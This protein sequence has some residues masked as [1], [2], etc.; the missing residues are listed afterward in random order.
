MSL[1]NNMDV[2]IEEFLLSIGIFGPILSCALILIESIIAVLP[3]SVFITIN[4]IYFGN[5]IGFIISYIFTVLGCYLS[6]ILWRKGLSSWFHAKV[7]NRKTL[8]NLMFKFSNISTSALAAL[9][10]MP[11]TPAFLVNIA[12]GLC[13]MSR[14]KFLTALIIGKSAMV[15]FW[16]YIGVNLLHSFK[17]PIILIRIIFIMLVAYIVSKGLNKI[18]KIE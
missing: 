13:D 2:I 5:I 4:F 15:Y 9:M 14:K 17:D 11:F 8:E 1:L 12:A 18:L 7:N 3:L 10:A 6:Y 16:G